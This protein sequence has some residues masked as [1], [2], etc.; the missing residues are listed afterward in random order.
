M[1]DTQSVGAQR[2]LAWISILVVLLAIAGS[3]A[4]YVGLPMFS[5]VENIEPGPG[6]AAQPSTRAE[7][8]DRYL[9]TQAPAY[10]QGSGAVAAPEE[11]YVQDR[12]KAKEADAQFEAAAQE[13]VVEDPGTAER[14]TQLEAFMKS[15]SQ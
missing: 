3:I 9:K 2:P 4:F 8:L 13:A 14:R 5:T 1:D 15:K 11:Q 7:E 12:E 6:I 10:S